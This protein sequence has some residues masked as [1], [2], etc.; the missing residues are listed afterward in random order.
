M[1][2]VF[3]EAW[4]VLKHEG[5]LW[6]NIGDSYAGSGLGGGSKSLQGTNKGSF[7]PKKKPSIPEGL[8][9]KDLIGIPWMLAFA[10][11]SEGW[12]LRQDII[13]AK[14]NCMP[15]SVKDRCTRSHEHLFMFSKQPKYYYNA[16]AIKEHAIYYDIAGMDKTGYKNAKTFKG[17]HSDKQRGHTRRHAGFNERWDNMTTQEQ[18]SGLRNKR[19]VW[20][21]APAQYKDAHFAVFPPALIM[22]PI[23]AGSPPGGLVM[24]PFMGSGTT[25]LVAFNLGRNYVGLELNPEY[26]KIAQKRIKKVSGLFEGHVF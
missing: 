24:D 16:E 5:T 21:I 1:V 7:S 19:D 11:R 10:L 12:H 3:K 25:G 14:P 6:I 18:C 4:R 26:I 9:P 17:K 20:T 8:K 13:W 2:S 15:E 23:K 22:D